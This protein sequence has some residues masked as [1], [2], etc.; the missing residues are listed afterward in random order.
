MSVKPLV[1]PR[2]LDLDALI[3]IDDP[4]EVVFQGRTY[5][6][7]RPH[8]YT[9]LQ[10]SRYGRALQELEELRGQIA[11]VGDDDTAQRNLSQRLIAVTKQCLVAACPDLAKADIPFYLM[12]RI[13]EH[14]RTEVQRAESEKKALAQQI[15]ANPPTGEKSAPS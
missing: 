10:V 3:G 15:A 2:V 4:I 11:V 5:R 13:L 1:T 8:A 7:V 12:L 14:Y 9:P 6:M